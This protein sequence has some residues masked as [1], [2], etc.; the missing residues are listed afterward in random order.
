MTDSSELAD[1]LKAAE[2]LT[3]QTMQALRLYKE[4]VDSRQGPAEMDRLRQDAEFLM[5]A[6]SDYQLQV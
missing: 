5:Q 3:E 1:G 2:K 6:L 4:A